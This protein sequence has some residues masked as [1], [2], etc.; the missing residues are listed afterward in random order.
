MKIAAPLAALAALAFALAAGAQTQD[1]GDSNETAASS[2]EFE[3]SQALCRELRDR[4]PPEADRPTPAQARALEGCDSEALYYGIGRPADP[5]KARQCAFLEAERDSGSAF[6]GRAMLMTIYVNG[7][8]ARRDLD[9][10]IHLA[11]GLEG[12]PAE[13]HGWVT[14][15][16]ELRDSRWSGSD[17]GYC[18]DI[19][20]GLA[21]GYCA[22]HEA[23]IAGARREARLTQLVARWT[24]RERRLLAPLRQAFDIYVTAHGDGE[25]D[26]TGTARR[27]MATGAEEALR[28]EFLAMIER[29][30]SGRAPHLSSARFQ[31]DDAA[32][33]TAYRDAIRGPFYDSPGSVTREGIRDAQRAWL[34]YRDA[35]L[36][37]AA[38]RYPQVQRDSL[39]AWLTEQ[40]TVRLRHEDE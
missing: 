13:S 23:R 11:C 24:P 1:W 29:L 6:S 9:V 2:E 7:V 35:F 19:T 15:L 12:A 30:D 31:A 10:A 18:D 39:A 8:G 33:N 25:V 14:H 4:E 5:V 22:D 28:D 3:A 21:M 38:L 16:A 32:L 36:A 34:R 26:L 20:S 17:F 40:R 27:A 37:F